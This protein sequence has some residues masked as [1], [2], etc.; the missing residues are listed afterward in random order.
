[1]RADYLRVSPLNMKNPFLS[2]LI[3]AVLISLGAAC[4]LNAQ[5]AATEELPFDMGPVRER[6]EKDGVSLATALQLLAFEKLDASELAPAI[7]YLT[8]IDVLGDDLVYG[9]N[10]RFLS[11]RQR[12]GFISALKAVIAYRIGEYE[13]F[14]GLVKSVVIDAPGYADA[15]GFLRMLTQLRQSEVTEA[16]LVNF[17][18]PMD[19]EVASVDGETRTLREWMGDNKALLIDFWASWCGP[20]IQLMPELKTKSE[21]LSAQGIYVAGFNTDDSDQ[22]NKTKQVQETH[23]M[24]GVPW[25]LD[26]DGSTLSGMLYVDSIPRMVLIDPEGKV[27]YNGHPMDPG[28]A[29]ALVEF[30]VKL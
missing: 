24:Q 26:P 4:G 19:M 23:E 18:V 1:M 6:A 14:E 20:C 13:R 25:L 3:A 12:K 21:K 30:D 2:S 10:E 7:E 5:E 22:L 17:R 9:R 8:A 16:A 11:V 28:L 15:F 29:S 27:R